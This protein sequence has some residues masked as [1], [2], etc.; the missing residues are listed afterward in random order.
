MQRGAD[1]SNQYSNYWAVG[2]LDDAIQTFTPGAQP[3]I[4]GAKT[5][6]RSEDDNF[7]ITYDRGGDY[8]R[9]SKKDS[10]GA[11]HYTLPDGSLPKLGKYSH[12]DD[13]SG[14]TEFDKQTHIKNVNR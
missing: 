6:Y 9:I 4:R 2:N 10:G 11:R 5:I 12:R 8:Y 7:E 14:Q 3:T 1:A 13:G